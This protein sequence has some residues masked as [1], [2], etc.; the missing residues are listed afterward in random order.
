MK[1]KQVVNMWKAVKKSQKVK[2]I[3]SLKLKIQLIG[4][5]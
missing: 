3:W 2:N 1:Q 4:H 5:N